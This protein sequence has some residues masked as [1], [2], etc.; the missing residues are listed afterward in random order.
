MG[1]SSSLMLLGFLFIQSIVALFWSFNWLSYPF[2]DKMVYFIAAYIGSEVL[3]VDHLLF[4][5]LDH[6]ADL[7]GS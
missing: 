4:G 5:F 2:P 6:M 1:L 3:L 7:F